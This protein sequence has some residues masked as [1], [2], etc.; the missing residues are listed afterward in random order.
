[1]GMATLLVWRRS[2]AA[3]QQR[4]KAVQLAMREY[5]GEESIAT[6]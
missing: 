1:M 2:D 3:V 4:S 5:S 6:K